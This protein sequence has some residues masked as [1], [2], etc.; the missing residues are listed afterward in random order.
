MTDL[1]FI[2]YLIMAGVL[3]VIVYALIATILCLVVLGEALFAHIGPL[4]G[5]RAWTIWS[6]ML[7]KI[8]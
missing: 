1:T 5:P 8:I 6:N 7:R 2:V 3:S 4:L